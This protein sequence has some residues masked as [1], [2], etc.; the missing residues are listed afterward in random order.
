MSIADINIPS[1]EVRI[2]SQASTAD[3]RSKPDALLSSSYSFRIFV[4]S[5]ISKA[6]NVK[7]LENHLSVINRRENSFLLYITPHVGKPEVLENSVAWI[8][9]K[10]IA[11]AFE[12]YLENE[13]YQKTELLE[14]LIVEFRKLVDNLGLADSGWNVS[15]SNEQVLIVPASWAE[16]IALKYGYYIC[17]NNRS[18]RPSKYIAFYNNQKIKHVFEIKESP[19][20]DVCLSGENRFKEYIS[21]EE[22]N[23]LEHDLRKVILVKKTLDVNIENDKRDKNGKICA[24]V[25]MQT[26]SELSKLK[27]ASYTSEL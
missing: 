25:Q 3:S 15:N 11:T 22:P 19:K 2:L 24:Y 18:F 17:Q 4:E 5:K 20:N 21:N 1:S 26:Y 9:W 7:Q 12:E 23:Y 14:F 13:I 16:R 8:N 10:S 27:Q 6:I